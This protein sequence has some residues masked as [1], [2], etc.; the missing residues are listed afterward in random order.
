MQGR[1]PSDARVIPQILTGAAGC[2]DGA[3]RGPAQTHGAATGQGGG[4]RE[5]SRST[6]PWLSLKAYGVNT[7][8][9]HHRFL[10]E[11]DYNF[12]CSTAHSSKKL[13]CY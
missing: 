12:K 6:M 1:R 8:N 11:S 7:K 2:E 9:L 4:L 13:I 5:D 3:M 10:A